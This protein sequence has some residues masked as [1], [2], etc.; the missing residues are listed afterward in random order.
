MWVTEVMDQ[1]H[2]LN[3]QWIQEM[4]FIREID[5]ALSKSLM[6]EFLCLKVLMGEDLGASLRAWQVEMEAI[7]DNLLQDLDAAAQVSTTLPSQNAAV[8]TALWQFRA[9]VQLRMALSLT[10]LDEAHKRM[11]EFIQSH[12]R[13]LLSQQE[14]KNLIGEL[15]SWITDH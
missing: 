11:E 9:A 8:G 5:H 3:L 13:E 7:T 15:S 10:W 6:V 2:D 1:V 12:L 14:M 4:G